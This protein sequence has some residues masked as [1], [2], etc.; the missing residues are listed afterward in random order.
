MHSQRLVNAFVINA[1]HFDITESHQ[2]LAHAHRVAFH[3]DPPVWAAVT[4]PIL[5]DPPRSTADTRNPYCPL[6]SEEPV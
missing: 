1:E 3:R 2:Q 4:A 5:G 6:I